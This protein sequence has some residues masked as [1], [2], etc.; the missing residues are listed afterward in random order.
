MFGGRSKDNPIGSAEEIR[1]ACGVAVAPVEMDGWIPVGIGDPALVVWSFRA[2]GLGGRPCRWVG[3]HR[4]GF[5]P[6]P[7]CL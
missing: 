7:I 4:R 6:P 1:V 3:R 5:L 2:F